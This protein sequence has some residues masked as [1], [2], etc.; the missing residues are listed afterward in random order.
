MTDACVRQYGM[1]A[2]LR[3]LLT[4]KYL[5]YSK[6]G[7]EGQVKLCSDRNSMTALVLEPVFVTGDTSKETCRLAHACD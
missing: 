2:R 1:V 3:H 6:L 5:C 7:G 4:Q